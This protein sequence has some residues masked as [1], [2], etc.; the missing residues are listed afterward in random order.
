MDYRKINYKFWQKSYYAPNVESYIFRFYGY[1]LKKK[2]IN[3]ILDF[4]CGQGAAT[5]FFNQKKIKTLGVDISKVDINKAKK[6]YKKY[7]NN[8]IHVNSIEDLSRKID[9]KYDVI[10]AGQS[11][12][13]LNNN[14][15]NRVLN[16]LYNSLKKNG[17]IFASMI[18]SK[19]TLFKNSRKISNQAGNGIREVKGDNKRKYQ[20]HFINFT[21]GYSDLLE[22]FKIFKK[23]YVGYYSICFDKNNDLNHHYTFIGCKK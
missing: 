1:Y 23:L 12:Y 20:K 18:S 4:G 21:K 8:F 7:K 17:V 6:K 11:L 19:S 16:I 15:L 22:K 10:I 9:K 14:D 5:N 13:Y 3:R 2:K